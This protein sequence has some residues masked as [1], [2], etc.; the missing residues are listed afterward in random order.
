M[1][2]SAYKCLACGKLHHPA[3]SVCQQ[4]GHREFEEVPLGG[5]CK[6]LTYTRLFNL[7]EGYMKPWLDFGIVE[8][9]NGVRASGQIECKEMKTGMKLK[10]TVGVVKEGVGQDYYGFIFVEA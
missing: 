1:E 8:F 10:S 6:L 4:C 7:P 9:E 3:Y 2:M 5:E